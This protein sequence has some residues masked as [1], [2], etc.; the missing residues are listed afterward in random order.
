MNKTYNKLKALD[1]V[2]L[3]F[4]KG[5]IVALLGPNGS[6]KTTLLK[7]ILGLVLPESGDI[8]VNGKNIKRD[9]RYR[10]MIGYM[11]QTASYP[12]N[13]KV[14]EVLK[15]IKDIRNKKEYEDEL[16]KE[17]KIE[18]MYCKKINA[19]SQGMKQR[20]SAALTFLFDSDIIILDEPTAGLD[21]A[22]A[23]YLKMKI[24]KEKTK[25]KLIIVTTHIIS[26]VEE[27][28]D[29]FIFMH[30]G[31]VKIEDGID[32]LKVQNNG[33]RKSISNLFKEYE[34]S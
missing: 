13:L 32:K 14:E 8:F 4:E 27:L 2:D 5:E 3:F 16:M 24:L 10:E 6:G 34:W 26:E 29:R 17:L 28:A 21:P 1:N 25:G 31:R 33:F 23:D 30:E 15:I 22:S 9:F 11:P 20:L 12:E 18:E 7:S 19:L